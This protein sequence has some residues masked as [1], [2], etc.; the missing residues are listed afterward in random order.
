MEN[1]YEPNY[2]KIDEIYISEI[3]FEKDKDVTDVTIFGYYENPFEENLKRVDYCCDF[4]VLTDLL[5][6]AEEEGEIL[7]NII[8]EKLDESTNEIPS[9]IDVENLLGSPLKIEN[10]ILTIYK[11]FE[12]DENGIWKETSNNKD[13]FYF[14]DKL[15]LKDEIENKN[16]EVVKHQK[17]LSNYLLLLNNAYKFYLQ[18]RELKI[19]EKEARSKS[20]LKDELL[21]RIAYLNY[22]IIKSD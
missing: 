15:E 1:G 7:I 6:Y 8:A 4:S 20:G 2:R 21:F 9:I 16:N 19:K 14:I 13:E 5:I 22:K 17:D 3:I 18:L 10:I 12:K 11:P